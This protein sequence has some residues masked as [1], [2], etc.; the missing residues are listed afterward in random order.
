MSAKRVIAR[1]DVKGN[2]LIKG[3]HLE[4]W[5]FLG[6]PNK[7]CKKYYNAGID[8]II[9]IDAVASLYGRDMLK[10]VVEKTT[11][12][13]FIPITAGGGI[14]CIDDAYELLRA[15]ADKVAINSGALKNPNLITEISKKFGTQCVVLSIQAKKIETKWVACYDSARE[16]T[17]LDVLTW[18]KRAEDLGAGEILLTSVDNDGTFSGL[19]IELTSQVS[20]DINI[21]LIACGGVRS[22]NDFVEGINN[23]KAD[24]V[25]IAKALHFDKLKISNLKKYA[26]ENGIEIR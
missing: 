10:K 12:Q 26:K 20:K 11:D 16:V 14:R 9:Y 17:N 4:G 3:I 6:D 18:A 23:G 19:D 21:P 8:E 1:L 13:V 15:G 7:Y 25:A 22:E 24:A 2:R 5:R